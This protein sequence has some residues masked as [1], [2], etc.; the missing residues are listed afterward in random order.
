MGG[1]P[2]VDFDWILDHL[3]DIAERLVQHVQLTIIPVVLGFVI[4]L[5]LAIW[6]V[7]QPRVYGP[8]VAISGILYTIPSIAAFALL[9][10]DLR[11]HADHRGHPADD[12]HAADPRPQ[13]RV[14][15]RGRAGRRPRGGRGD[16]LHPLKGK[17]RRWL[18]QWDDV[19]AYCEAARHAGGGGAVIVLLRGR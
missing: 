19:L 10:P 12:L 6:A 17:V 4:S 8:I 16:G 11:P 2:L 7:R 18:S 9:H 3:D 1:Q 15:L 13:Q 14:G 5:F